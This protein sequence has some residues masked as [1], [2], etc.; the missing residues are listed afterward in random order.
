MTLNRETYGHWYSNDN[1]VVVINAPNSPAMP[2]QQESAQ[3]NKHV[4]HG[5]LG[6]VIRFRAWTRIS[7]DENNYSK[8]GVHAATPF[9]HIVRGLTHSSPYPNSAQDRKIHHAGWD[10]LSI[11]V[12][13]DTSPE[14]VIWA[15]DIVPSSNKAAARPQL[16]NW[17]EIYLIPKPYTPKITVAIPTVTGLKVTHTITN[18]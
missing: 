17:C 4:R 16:V 5:Q 7:S 18:H 9:I 1:E 12:P 15:R 14:A 3:H 10:T 8:H 6:A 13:R 11:I 2:D